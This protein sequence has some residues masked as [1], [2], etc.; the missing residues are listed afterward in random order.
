MRHI[1][2]I[3]FEAICRKILTEF[4]LSKTKK[5]HIEKNLNTVYAGLDRAA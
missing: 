4:F 1:L 3:L 5:I 2:S